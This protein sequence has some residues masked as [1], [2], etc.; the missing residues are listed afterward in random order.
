[1]NE[2]FQLDKNS[3][4][5]K[6]RRK[7]SLVRIVFSPMFFIVLFMIVEVVLIVSFIDIVNKS[8]FHYFAIILNVV[9]ILY[10]VNSKKMKDSFKITWMI[11]FVLM[12]FLGAIL[13]IILEFSNLFNVNRNKLRNIVLQ[14]NKYYDFSYSNELRDKINTNA[15]YKNIDDDIL[16]TSVANEASFFNYFDKNVKVPVYK[17]TDVKYFNDGKDILENILTS[18]KNA[19]KFIFIEIFILSDGIVW[20][21]LFNILKEKAKEGVEVKI[22]VDGLNSVLF[23]NNDYCRRLANYGIEAKI[24]K[25][26]SPI[27]SNTQNHRDHRK[28]FVIDNEVAYTGGINIADEYA[29]LYERFGHW[30]DAGVKITGDSVQSFTIMFLQLWYMILKTN[31]ID[32]SKYIDNK[33]IVEKQSNDYSAYVPYTDYP[34][35][36]ENISLQIFRYMFNTAKKYVYIMTPY[37]VIDEALVDTIEAAAKRGV[38]IRI[39]VP[40]IPDKKYVFYVNRS[41]YRSLTLAGAKVYEYM[42]G[43]VHAKVYLQD[44]IRSVV[45][46]ANLDYRS[47]YLHYENGLYIFGDKAVIGDI[48]ADFNAVFNNCKEMTLEEIIKIPARQRFWGAILKMFAPLM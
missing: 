43:F 30:K 26:I 6:N 42:P 13:Y 9:E 24:F 31:I 29:N 27:F 48:K 22:L 44:D 41:Y 16:K 37:L 33:N 15:I 25:P 11:L 17:N 45:G 2:K 14:S 1:M 3:E 34:S 7:S 36:S 23:F 4:Y 28:I 10:I 47:L 12:P 21:E 40:R 19:K 38:D 39:I 8:S 32:F 20:Q 46:T 35:L 18:V 5:A